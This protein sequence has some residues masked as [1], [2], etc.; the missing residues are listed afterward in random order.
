MLLAPNKEH[1]KVFPNVLAVGFQNGKNLK[2][3]L[4]RAH[5]PFLI[6]AKDVNHVEKNLFGLC[7]YKHC[8]NLY[9]K[10][11]SGNLKFRVVPSKKVL[12]LLKC[13]VCWE[14]S[15]VW[16]VKTKFCHRFNNYKSRHR[17]FRKG[18][19]S[20]FRTVNIDIFITYRN[21]GRKIV[22]P[23]RIVSGTPAR[24]RKQIEFSQFR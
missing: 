12:Y 24:L 23:I 17:A 7:L 16:K 11:L 14:V 13:K 21:S 2:D 20:Q 15:Y 8:Y 9:N 10:S 5:Y 1:K 18:N 4:V 3:Y 6:R 19:Q 22:Q